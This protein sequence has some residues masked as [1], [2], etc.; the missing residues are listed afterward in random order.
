MLPLKIAP[1]ENKDR[2]ELTFYAPPENADRVEFTL[3]AP[4]ENCF[5]LK[6]QIR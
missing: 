3:Y 4:P 5:P 1:P 2:V 6:I